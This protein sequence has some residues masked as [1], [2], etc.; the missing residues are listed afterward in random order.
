MGRL[1][2]SCV[3]LTFASFLTLVIP[4]KVL[5]GFLTEYPLT[6]YRLQAVFWGNAPGAQAAPHIS[7]FKKS[8]FESLQHTLF[9]PSQ[10]QNPLD[11]A[12]WCR[13]M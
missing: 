10:T 6:T 4:T 3:A 7:N 9:P 2:C 13:E 8:A 5:H 11:S 12:G 1:H